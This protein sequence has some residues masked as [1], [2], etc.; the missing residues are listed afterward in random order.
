M[1]TAMYSRDYSKLKSIDFYNMCEPESKK[2]VHKTSSFREE[3]VLSCFYVSFLY[4]IFYTL[5]QKDMSK[6]KSNQATEL[7]KII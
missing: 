5:Q 2:K 6:H 4:I 7:L 1:E 3:A